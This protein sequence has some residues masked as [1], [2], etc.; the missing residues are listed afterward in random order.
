MIGKLGELVTADAVVQWIIIAVL[1]IYFLCKEIPHLV[2]W[3]KH[4]T[5]VDGDT[6]SER[7]DS[8][9][10]C[11]N[12]FNEKLDRDYKRINVI[13]KEMELQKKETIMQ[14]S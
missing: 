2:R 9:E 7:I 8:M 11:Q 13:E 14:L 3:L 10:K 12:G 5:K 1:V 6:L 4:A